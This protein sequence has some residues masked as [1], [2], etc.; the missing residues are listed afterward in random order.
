MDIKK[1]LSLVAFGFL[2]TLLTI[3]LTLNG[4]ALDVTPD[5]IGWFLLVLSFGKLG[6]YCEGKGYLK[7]IFIALMVI[8]AGTWAYGIFKPELKLPSAVGTVVSFAEAVSM[9]IFFG[10][11]IRI[12]A[13]ISSPREGT[14]RTLRVL[15]LVFY[16]GASLIGFFVAV[17]YPGMSTADLQGVQAVLVMLIFGFAIA[18]I[19]CAIAT[20]VTLFKLRNDVSEKE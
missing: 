2:F 6:S 4:S 17:K 12:A 19:V 18:L 14:L 11:L 9:F 13:D 1:G 20:A 7:G 3:N 8:T 15:N 16:L 5:F 10:I